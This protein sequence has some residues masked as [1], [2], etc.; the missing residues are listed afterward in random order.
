[1]KTGISG[2]VTARIAAASQSRGTAQARI[3]ERR[4]AASTACGR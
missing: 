3:A 2:A 1:M 4:Q